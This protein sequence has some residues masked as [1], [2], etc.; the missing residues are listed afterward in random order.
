MRW[1]TFLDWEGNFSG[2]YVKLWECKWWISLKW[3]PGFGCFKGF[4]LFCW[5]RFLNWSMS[6]HSWNMLKRTWVI[7]C[8]GDHSAQERPNLQSQCDELQ[9]STGILQ[10]DVFF[11]STFWPSSCFWVQVATFQIWTWW[12]DTLLV[13]M[14]ASTMS[15]VSFT[16]SITWWYITKNLKSHMEVSQT[17][18]SHMPPKK[19]KYG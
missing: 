14:P 11:L 3:H 2:D 6:F 17:K 13:L 19:D 18:K 1:T 12:N 4:L 9:R 16:T 10:Q 5:K 15:M 8:R 7:G